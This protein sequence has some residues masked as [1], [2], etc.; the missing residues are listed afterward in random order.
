MRS[1]HALDVNPRPTGSSDPARLALVAGG[2]PRRVIVNCAAHIVLTT[3]SLLAIYC[4]LPVSGAD[5]I[6]MLLYFMAGSAVFV[7]ALGW[8][9]R[10]IV[11]AKHPGLR[12]FEAVGMVL[13]LFVVGFA[14]VYV[15][16][17]KADPNSFSEP[18]DRTAGL[19]FTISVLSTVGFGDI[20]PH[21]QFARLMVSLQMI[22]DLVLTGSVVR[23]LVSAARTGLKRERRRLRTRR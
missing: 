2:I 17:A 19:Y 15:S 14:T 21:T 22:L 10:S 16:M 5:N 13:P 18:L 3:L 8:H 9:V 7:V 6:G 11:V 23:L 1:L 20:T 12:A 4:L